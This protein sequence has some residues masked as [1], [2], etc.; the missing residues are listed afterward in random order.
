MPESLLGDPLND[1]IRQA[2]QAAIEDVDASN[3]STADRQTV[4]RAALTARLGSSF[5]PVTIGAN[6]QAQVD[7]FAPP[8]G[9]PNDLLNRIAVGMRSSR[10]KIEMVYAESDGA[11]ELV[12]SAKKLPD[13]KSVATKLLAQL[14]VGARQA[15]GLEEWTPVSAIRPVVQSYGRLDSKN[16]ATHMQQL[17]STCLVRG[18]GSQREL[19]VTKPGMEEIANLVDA[20]A[21][22]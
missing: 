15:A 21:S 10:D 6:H 12:I 9:D 11:P 14:V 17:D 19:K 3:V 7:Q 16:F 5:G 4:L 8:T 13:L 20:L 2:I 22:S 18:K 1:T